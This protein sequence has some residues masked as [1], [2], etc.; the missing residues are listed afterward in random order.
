MSHEEVKRAVGLF[1]SFVYVIAS[2][3]HGFLYF[4]NEYMIIKKKK[5]KK[6]RPLRPL[7]LSYLP[8]DKTPT[9]VPPLQRPNIWRLETYEGQPASK[10]VSR[11]PRDFILITLHIRFQNR[12]RTNGPARYTSSETSLAEGKV[13]KLHL[14]VFVT[15]ANSTLPLRLPAAQ[16]PLPE[17]RGG[18][19]RGTL[20]RSAAR[21]PAEE[22]A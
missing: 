14:P 8:P 20:T 21:R 11:D 2:A 1:Y 13:S 7:H 10:W 22:R 19:R 5:E 16:P 17:V 3:P 6:K 15:D 12:R 18:I 9:C 4:N